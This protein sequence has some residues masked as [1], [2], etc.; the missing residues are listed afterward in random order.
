MREQFEALSYEVRHTVGVLTFNRPEARN[1][2]DMV[3]RTEIEAILPSIRDDKEL[4]SL[5]ITGSGGFFCAG[6]DL[7]S[8]SEGDRSTEQ[9]RERIARLHT[10]FAQLTRLEIPVISAVDGPAFGAGLSLALGAD[11][12]L[13]STRARFCASFGR[14]GLVPDLGGLFVLPRLVGLQR[15]KE[16]VFSGRSV[17]AEEAKALGMVLE[18]Y[19]PDELLDAA[20][21]YAGRFRH[22]SPLAIG[23][24][25]IA[26]NQ[27]F[28]LDQRA[29]ADMEAWAQAICLDSAYHKAAVQRFLEKEPVEF[30]W[31][32]MDREHAE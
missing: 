14:F 23:Q 32:R 5:I 12:V 17:F 4:R 1:A 18:I 31:D 16:I 26:L 11:I 2:L 10:W 8:L 30:D 7:K 21:R 15:A 25:K 13:A 20:L 24:A 22:A 29:L 9:N 28:N 27:S 6:G 3:L 19:P